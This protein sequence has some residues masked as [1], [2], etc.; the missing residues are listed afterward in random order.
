MHK[1]DIAI[2]IGSIKCVHMSMPYSYYTRDWRRDRSD[3]S[4]Q[5]PTTTRKTQAHTSS[6]T[7]SSSSIF[8]AQ[9]RVYVWVLVSSRFGAEYVLCTVVKRTQ[10]IAY[11]EFHML[12]V[13]MLGVDD[14]RG[15]R[16]VLWCSELSK[17]VAHRTGKIIG[18]AIFPGAGAWTGNYNIYSKY[19]SCIYADSAEIYVLYWSLHSVNFQDSGDPRWQS[20]AHS[21]VREDDWECSRGKNTSQCKISR[22]GTFSDLWIGLRSSW[23]NNLEFSGH[24]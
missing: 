20:C 2:C 23:T 1:T 19:K 3:R 6:T 14:Q 15:L 22:Y 7:T 13:M 18:S 4:V 11:S 10:K 5:V 9:N 21:Q 17:C 8:F 12:M 24:K 16:G